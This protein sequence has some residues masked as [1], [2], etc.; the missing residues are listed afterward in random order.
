MGVRTFDIRVCGYQS[1]IHE[2]ITYYTAHTYLCIPLSEVLQQ[3]K[4]FIDTHPSEIISLSIRND[5]FTVN[6]DANT[7]STELVHQLD[8]YDKYYR[9]DIF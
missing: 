1:S 7:G 8:I 3:L 6:L 4:D 9:E 5:N 2:K